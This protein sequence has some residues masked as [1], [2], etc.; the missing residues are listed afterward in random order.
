[1]RPAVHFVGFKPDQRY[2][3]AVLVWGLP[4]FIHPGW[5][6]RAARE[7]ADVDTVVFAKGGADQT[8]RSRSYDDPGQ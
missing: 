8:P 4:D 6:R 7:I 2:A 1:M 3:N 5:D